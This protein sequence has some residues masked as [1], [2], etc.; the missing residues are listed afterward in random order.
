MSPTPRATSAITTSAKASTSERKR[1]FSSFSA[2]AGYSGKGNDA[3]KIDPR[4][5]EVAADWENL[6]SGENYLGRD[7]AEGFSSPGGALVGKS[8]TYAA[9]GT[10]RLNQWALSGDWTVSAGAAALDKANGRVVYRFH[11]RD[12]HLVM[13][14]ATRG[15]SVR[16]RVLLDG[17]PPG[18]RSRH[19]HRRAGLRHGHGTAALPA[20]PAARAHCGSNLRD[21]VSGPRRGGLRVYVRV[22]L[23]QGDTMTLH[24]ASRISRW[25]LIAGLASSA[26]AVQA[27][28][29]Y[30]ITPSDE[31]RISVGM[32]EAEVRQ[33]FGPPV[34]TRHYPNRPGP[35]WTYEV[36]GA[37]F[38]RTDFNIDFGAD[39][40]VVITSEYLY[41][42]RHLTPASDRPGCAHRAPKRRIGNR[43]SVTFRRVRFRWRRRCLSRDGA[44]EIAD[45]PR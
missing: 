9:P 2:E 38:G 26:A 11:S 23:T 44:H 8:R 39:G 7:K 37:P 40:K 12:V 41:G 34:R 5:S 29:G 36:R 45:G 17:R 20:H 16:F 6:R 19:R 21:R 15:S 43:G 22:M 31:A 24:I 25:L 33:L 13:G 27:A 1:S 14:P 35:S 3:V 30:W 42:S 32:T 18:Q 10:L 28:A 4:G